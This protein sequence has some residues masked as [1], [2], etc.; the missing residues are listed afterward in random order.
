MQ[1][2]GRAADDGMDESDAS[3]APS[4][5]GKSKAPAK[6]AA[7]ATKAAASKGKSKALAKD[8]LV[9][10]VFIQLCSSM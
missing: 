7:P 6:K 1:T 4:T 10:F 3:S 5:R 9:R 2:K 8:K